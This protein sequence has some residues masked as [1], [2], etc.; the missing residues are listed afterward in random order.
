MELEVPDPRQE[1]VGD[2][3]FVEPRR[4]WPGL[5]I[6]LRQAASR[7]GSET[8]RRFHRRLRRRGAGDSTRYPARSRRLDA[9]LPY[10][11]RPARN[12]VDIST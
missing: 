5:A 11:L 4:T 6:V 1:Q 3:R 7:T 2:E 10:L 12:K 9:E 8:H